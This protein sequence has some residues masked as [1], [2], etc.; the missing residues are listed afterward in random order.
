MRT[1]YLTCLLALSTVVA[2]QDIGPNSRENAAP[3]SY[4]IRLLSVDRK[5]SSVSAEVIIRN[6]SKSDMVID[7]GAIRYKVVY[8][9][10]PKSIRDGGQGPGRALTISGDPGKNYV[11]DF[12]VLP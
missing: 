2:A 3:F 6:Q 11:G 8:K 7:K 10:E 1:L 4:R 12:L 5:N 9:K